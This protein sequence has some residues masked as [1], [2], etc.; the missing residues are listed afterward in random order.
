MLVYVIVFVFLNA[1]GGAKSPPAIPAAA[2]PTTASASMASG[3]TAT[4]SLG[5]YYT[6]LA[7]QVSN[8]C[9]EEGRALPLV[10][11]GWVS[12][13][14]VPHPNEGLR[15][16]GGVWVWVVAVDSD[17]GDARTAI[18]ADGTT[19]T[20]SDNRYRADGEPVTDF[21][22]G[23]FNVVSGTGELLPGTYEVHDVEECYW[24]R[25][26]DSGET[27]DNNFIIAAPSRGDG[28]GRRRCIH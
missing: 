28:G 3:T 8:A 1:C 4:T 26:D 13:P 18:R 15:C 12:R 5:Q 11:R 24:E 2:P 25:V 20:C 17:C 9:S 19:V 10:D 7:R 22:A 21:Y 14:L 23:T 27:I 6:A 16:V